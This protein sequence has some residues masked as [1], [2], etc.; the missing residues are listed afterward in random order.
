[1]TEQWK[2]IPNYEGLY[3]VSN[4]GRVWSLR[5]KKFLRPT[6]DS[7]G[8]EIVG[9]YKDKRQK[10]YKVHRIV[11]MCFLPFCDKNKQVNH[12]DENKQ[13]N[14]SDNLEYCTASENINYGTRN[15][16]VSKALLKSD[17]IKERKAVEAINNDDD[18]HFIFLSLHD[19][20]RNGYGRHYITQAI[21]KNKIYRG[22][23]WRFYNEG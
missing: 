5:T 16:R 18:T 6:I 11:A 20:E 13:N 22:F 1:M 7:D 10:K 14:R 21:K 12:I 9:L 19:A 8:Y 4:F 17:R 2:S 23:M 15:N 3:Y